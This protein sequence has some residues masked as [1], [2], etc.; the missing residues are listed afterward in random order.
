MVT[1]L[2]SRCGEGERSGCPFP[3]TTH[4]PAVLT[5]G[6]SWLPTAK[7]DPTQQTTKGKKKKVIYI[8]LNSDNGPL[9]LMGKKILPAKVKVLVRLTLK[10]R[11]RCELM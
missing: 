1:N 2:K 7:F 5:C 4:P 11:Y 9:T 6:H 3:H 10:T 8:V